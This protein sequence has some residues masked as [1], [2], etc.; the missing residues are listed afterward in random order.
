M[1]LTEY[2]QKLEVSDPKDDRLFCELLTEGMHFLSL[3]DYECARMFDVSRPS[4][5]R[6]MNT[7]T[8]PHVLMRKLVF[9]ELKKEAEH[10]LYV[11]SRLNGEK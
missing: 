5:T 2:I 6:W 11:K 7:S 1:T 8:K 4:V 9:D 3:T 10:Q